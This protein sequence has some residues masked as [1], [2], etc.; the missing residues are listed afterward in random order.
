MPVATV[1][2]VWSRVANNIPLLSVFIHL[3]TDIS[4]F[5]VGDS[6]P[7]IL[8]AWSEY[9]DSQEKRQFPSPV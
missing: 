9:D 4:I 7:R 2:G 6:Q 5:D 1:E 3:F 8:Q